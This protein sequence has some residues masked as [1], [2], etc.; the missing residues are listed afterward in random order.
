MAIL[1]NQGLPLMRPGGEEF[2]YAEYG[3]PVLELTGDTS[4][5]TKE[6]PV[7]LAYKYK[8]MAGTCE[9]KWQGSSSLSYPKKNYTI[10]FDQ[11]FEAKEGWGAQKKY[12]LKANFIDH[13]HARNVVSAKLWGDIVRSRKDNGVYGTLS[14]DRVTHFARDNGKTPDHRASIQ[15]GVVTIWTDIYNSGAVCWM[16]NKLRAGTHTITFDVYNPYDEET[17]PNGMVSCSVCGYYDNSDCHKQVPTWECYTQIINDRPT[18]Y[19]PTRQMWHTQQVTLYFPEDA[20]FSIMPFSCAP[21]HNGSGT[22]EG[23]KFRNILI[24]GKA[25]EE[26][27]IERLKALPNCG[28]IDGFPSIVTMNGEFHGLYTFN[29]PKDGWMFGM[30]EGANEAIVCAETHCDATKFKADAKLDGTD[31]DLEY[32]VSEEANAVVEFIGLATNAVN[33]SSNKLQYTSTSNLSAVGARLFHRINDVRQGDKIT[34]SPT[35]YWTR[36]IYQY[37]PIEVNDDLVLQKAT[38]G[39]TQITSPQSITFVVEKQN[40]TTVFLGIRGFPYD[41]KPPAYWNVVDNDFESAFEVTV[42]HGEAA[43]NTWIPKSLNRAISACMNSDGTDLD[44]VVDKYIDIAS[45]IDYYIFVQLLCGG[46]MTDKN[47]LLATFDGARWFFSSYDMDSTYGLVWDGKSFES[48]SA[49]PRF[50]YNHKL[51][52]LLRTHKKAAIK[53]RYAELR[54]SVMSEDNVDTAFLNFGA[55]VPSAVLAEDTKKWPTIPSSSVSN[56]AQ[57]LQWYRRR[58]EAIDKDIENL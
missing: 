30:G 44:S 42:E 57:I 13:S 12:C 24:D 55:G 27:P 5:M 50:D 22:T 46:D 37:E 18:A 7:T 41:E 1:L 53:E 9:V 20:E 3:L 8:D 35:E 15:D 11:E 47:Y 23:Y 48:V 17:D 58:I 25:P 4:A 19:T 52:E 16:G 40:T 32:A 45:A 43:R 51:M 26:E 33:T 54:K 34:I 38:P 31:F 28:A 29:I 21:L 49:S 56:T 39:Y 10:K 36:D 2:K 14:L 6:N